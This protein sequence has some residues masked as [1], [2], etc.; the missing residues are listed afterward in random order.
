MVVV[1][2]IDLDMLKHLI[3]QEKKFVQQNSRHNKMLALTGGHRY[4][5][6][7]VVVTFN[8]IKRC[9]DQ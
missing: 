7:D 9:M 6:F 4:E 5:T 1:N 3:V 2:V 8:K